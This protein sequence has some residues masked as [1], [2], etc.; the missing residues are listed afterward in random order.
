MFSLASKAA[1]GLLISADVPA[2]YQWA[3]KCD[4]EGQNWDKFQH[5]HTLM[6]HI[7]SRDQ[8]MGISSYMFTIADVNDNFNLERCENMYACL[9]A[10]YEKGQDEAQDNKNG[11]KCAKV[12][13]AERGPKVK[14]SP[15]TMG[16]MCAKE[17]PT[18]EGS[19]LHHE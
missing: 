14:V 19:P 11:M 6:P 7:K 9:A 8:C 4:Y 17:F 15:K 13:T 16:A 5:F 10:L 3:T 12:I 1:A 2:K 18:L